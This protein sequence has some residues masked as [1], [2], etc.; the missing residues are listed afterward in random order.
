MVQVVPCSRCGGRGRTVETQCGECRGQGRVKKRRK[1]DVKIPQ[2]VDTGTRLRISGEG[3]A[4][5]SGGPPGDLFIL[6]EV[7][8]D[9]RFQRS[10][11][12]LHM[13]VDI[14]V[15]QAALGATVLVP[16]FDGVEKLDI[17]GGTQP[18]SVLRI[19]NR[20]MPNLRGSG[21]GDLHIHVRVNVPKNL[22]ERGKQLMEDLA[23]E[24]KVEVTESK[25]IFDKIKDK[26]S[27]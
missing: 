14:A 18:G 9:N 13:K 17:P 25:G 19:K 3:G 15:P 12:D 7:L 24:M 5:T 10:G 8:Q 6:I 20:G 16:T 26:F 21:R 27:G 1:L 11:A 2:G 4:G 22:S 23:R